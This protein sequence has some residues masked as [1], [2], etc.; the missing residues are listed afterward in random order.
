MRLLTVTMATAV[1][2]LL[3]VPALAHDF[4]VGAIEVEHP[5]ARATVASVPNGGA[6]MEL[7][8]T[9]KEADRLVSAASPA[10]ERVELH[11][12]IDDGGVMKMRQV[13]AV[14]LAP[15][16][17]LKL[18]P[19]GLHVM[20]LGLKE[21]LVKGK[22]IPLTLTFEKAGA[23]TV[24]IEVQAAGDAKAAHEAKHHDHEH[25]HGDHDHEHEHEHKY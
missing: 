1:A 2:A 8:N 20:L 10:A 15:G 5:W 6:F 9:G 4:K 21:P 18:A 24:E 14:E 23:V 17:T 7:N 11:T 16:A 12:H 13:P 25:E 19:G 3:A 22:T